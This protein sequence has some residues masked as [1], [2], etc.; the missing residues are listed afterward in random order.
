MVESA[1]APSS[2]GNIKDASMVWEGC[3][4]CAKSEVEALRVVEKA[5]LENRRKK[6]F[7]EEIK[8]I[9]K[10]SEGAGAI[11]QTW[12]RILINWIKTRELKNSYQIT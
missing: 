12:I 4:V 10:G 5:E 2:M 6:S 1:F 3:I 9:E 11:T 8:V 7:G